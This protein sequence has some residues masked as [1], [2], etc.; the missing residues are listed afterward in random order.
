MLD[1]IRGSVW[2]KVYGREGVYG[3][4]CMGVEKGV[5]KV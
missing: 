3:K 4:G 5:P 2:E 1:W